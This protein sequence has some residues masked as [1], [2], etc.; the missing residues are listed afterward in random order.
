M[1][2]V[3]GHRSRLSLR[4]VRVVLAVVEHR[5]EQPISALAEIFARLARCVVAVQDSLQVALD[6]APGGSAIALACES[7]DVYAG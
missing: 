4:V 6:C 1:L 7:R 5:L 3:E 2:V